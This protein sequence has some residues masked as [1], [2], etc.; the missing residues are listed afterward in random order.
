MRRWGGVN[1]ARLGGTST[2]VRTLNACL[3]GQW[4]GP[5][6]RVLKTDSTPPAIRRRMV[7]RCLLPLCDAGAEFLFAASPPREQRRAYGPARTLPMTGTEM[8]P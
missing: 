6:G 4:T 3:G 1:S 7:R 5:S 8:Y 2:G